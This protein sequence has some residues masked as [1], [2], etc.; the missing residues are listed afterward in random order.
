MV[1]KLPSPGSAQRHRPDRSG[2]A[3]P[4]SMAEELEAVY[5]VW[6]IAGLHTAQTLLRMKE[7]VRRFSR[8]LSAADITTFV[9]VSRPVAEGFVTAS[10]SGGRPALIATQHARRTAVRTLYRT[11]RS[12]GYPVADP[13]LDIA[14]APRG[15]LVARPLTD[16]EITLCRAGA[17]LTRGHWASMR[18]TAW[19]LGETSAVSSEITAITIADL[20]EFTS[21]RHVRLPGTTRHDPRMGTLSDWGSQ[22]I[23]ARAAAL[24]A[25][26][27]TATTLLAY[28][29]QAPAGGAK[30][31]ASVCNAL[32]EVL[33]TAGL[34]DEP[35]V[36]PSS[37]RHWAGRRAYDDGAPIDAVARLLGHRS[38]DGAA[39]DIALRW[40]PNPAP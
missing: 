40:R 19:A 8:R 28:G 21:P 13:T 15:L 20:D 23:A 30:A 39:E 36:R 29:G 6:D 35:D 2:Q 33:D 25:S 7:T 22:V 5:S 38:L 16:D 32:R 37:L 11:L 27:A 26:G 34:A 12:L 9:D 1:R 17:Q 3:A 14:L 31:Q 10:V 18:A 4:S 24:Q